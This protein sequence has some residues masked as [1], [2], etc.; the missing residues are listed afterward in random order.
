MQW[1]VIDT[2]REPQQHF[3][4]V[5]RSILKVRGEHGKYNSCD[6]CSAHIPDDEPE[7][8]PPLDCNAAAAQQHCMQ[9]LLLVFCLQC[10]AQQR[11]SPA[12]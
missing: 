6:D 7:V 4:A 9:A 1:H 5:A 2:E 11:T 10:Y 3:D 12:K 8:S